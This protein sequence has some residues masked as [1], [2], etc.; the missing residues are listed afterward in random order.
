MALQMKAALVKETV[1]LGLDPSG[2]AKITFRQALP[3][4]T[5]VRDQLL[6]SQQRRTFNAEGM[7]IRDTVPWTV[8]QEIEIRLTIVGAEGILGPN[9]ANLFRFKGGKLNM[10][11]DEFHEAWGKINPISICDEFHELC[12]EVNPDWAP[13]GAGGDDD[14]DENPPQKLEGES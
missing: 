12:W 8:R 5:Q 13:G 14:D 1:L 7:E 2:E 9:G 3:T 4:E 11:P 6:F 10:T